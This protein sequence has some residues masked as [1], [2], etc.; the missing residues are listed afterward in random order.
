MGGS[1]RAMGA[2]FYLVVEEMVMV[3][4][5]LVVGHAIVSD[6]DL[7]ALTSCHYGGLGEQQPYYWTVVD[8]LFRFERHVSS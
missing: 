1:E 3:V 4:L 6:D 5:S 7:L 8:F 2:V